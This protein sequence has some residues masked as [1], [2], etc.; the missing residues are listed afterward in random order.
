MQDIS[1]V[2]EQTFLKFSP[3]SFWKNARKNT[4]MSGAVCTDAITIVEFS[5]GVKSNNI[6]HPDNF[7]AY[8][9]VFPEANGSGA[10]GEALSSPIVSEPMECYTDTFYQCRC[11]R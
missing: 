3:N 8:K 11:V 5:N 7:N 1:I 2:W 4:K 9:V 6:T 10:L